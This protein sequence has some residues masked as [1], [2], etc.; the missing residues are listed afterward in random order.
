MSPTSDAADRVILRV[1]QESQARCGRPVYRTALVKL[2]YLTDY[3]YAQHTGLTLTGFE[4]VWD[5]HGPNAVGNQIVKHAYLLKAPRGAIEID[6]GLTPS[7]NPKYSYRIRDGAT[8]TPLAD[9]LGDQIVGDVVAT[10]GTLNWSGIVNASK[11]TPPV[12]RAKPGDRLDLTPDSTKQQR[13]A[14][15]KAMVTGR[16]YDTTRPGTSISDL[17]ARYGLN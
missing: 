5:N 2:V 12:L 3:I 6:Q 9:D 17:K 14:R 4:Y 1:L 16:E 10:Y 13:L 7:G 15:A 11:A 8:A